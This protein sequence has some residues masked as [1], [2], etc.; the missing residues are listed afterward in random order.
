MAL[1]IENGSG[2]NN[3]ESYVDVDYVN[4]YFLKRGINEWASL[5]NREQLI[6]RAMDYIENN[7]TYQGTK[8]ISTQALAFP[9]VI[10]GETVYPIAIKNALCELALKANSGDLLQDT[11]KTTIREKVGTLEV[12][13]DPNQDDLTSYNYVNK[14]LAP[15]LVSTSSFSY[16]ISRV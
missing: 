2:M 6:I 5:T 4:A 7:Y 12:E 15:Y 1:I 13:Y 16:S 3:S 11:G 9:R 8:L 14:L 10:N